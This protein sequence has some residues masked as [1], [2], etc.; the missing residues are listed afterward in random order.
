MIVDLNYLATSTKAVIKNPN[1][2]IQKKWSIGNYYEAQRNG[3]LNFIFATENKGG[4]FIDIGASVG[5][6]TLFFASVMNALEVHS[7]EPLISSFE[8]L[9]E[10][11][12]LNGFET[13]VCHNV[14]IG[15]KEG[16]C[17]METI[18]EDNI[19]MTEIRE[20]TETRI[21]SLDQLDFIEGYDV[22][23]I[24]V[25]HYNEE[26]LKGAKK[27]FTAGTGSIYIECESIE[28][29]LLTDGYMIEYGYQ[30]VQGVVLNHT[31]TYKYIKSL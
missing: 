14:A 28:E 19:G 15:E 18:S 20:G 24:D 29:L 7:F 9:Q 30:R 11:V 12:D 10:N 21:V 31:P 26:L 1:D 13:V 2:H 17:R 27:T 4:K 23:K 22:I 16:T 5:N 8:H 3:M 6:H 25:E